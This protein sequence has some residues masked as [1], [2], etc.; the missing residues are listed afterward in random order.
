MYRQD[1]HSRHWRLHHYSH[2]RHQYAL[3]Q[4]HSHCRRFFSRWRRSNWNCQILECLDGRR[5][6]RRTIKVSKSVRELIVEI[7]EIRNSVRIRGTAIQTGID[8]PGRIFSDSCEGS[9]RRNFSIYLH[10]LCILS[11]FNESVFNLWIL[12]LAW[13]RLAD[14]ASLRHLPQQ[15]TCRCSEGFRSVSVFLKVANQRKES[16]FILE[17]KL[18]ILRSSLP[19]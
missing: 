7:H 3:H 8:E 16:N 15:G 2:H 11:R 14:G 6:S 19:R 4:N 17:R 12:R 13:S 9:K 18:E 1:L 10:V 5:S